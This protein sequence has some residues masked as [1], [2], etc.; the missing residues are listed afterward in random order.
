MTPELAMIAR[1]LGLPGEPGG[2]IEPAGPGRWRAVL[3]GESRRTVIVRRDADQE[4]AANH[5]WMMERLEAVRFTA[6]PHLLAIAGEMTVEEDVAGL[7]ALAVL[8]PPGSLEAAV[9]ALAALH[10]LRIGA[11]VDPLQLLPDEDTPL[12]RLGFSAA[13]R[14]P[15]QGPLREARTALRG[16]AVGLSLR[17]ANADRVLLAP[18]KAWLAD[19][20]EAGPGLQLFDVAAFLVTSGAD[21]ASRR[22]LAGTY[23]ELLGQEAQATANLVDLA[24]ILWGIE[25]ELGLPRRQIVAMGDDAAMERLVLTSSRVTRAFRE[26]A[27]EHALAEA[28][29]AALWPA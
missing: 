12:F 29:R 26:P 15:A 17:Y 27:G 14:E 8:P 2:S 3:D 6:K 1:A 18:G 16:T 28:I 25:H 19:F 9:A 5:A 7:D 11:A 13:E 22:R 21:P 10:G 23:G 24:A 4:R 20:G